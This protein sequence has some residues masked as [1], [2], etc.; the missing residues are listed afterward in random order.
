M[1]NGTEEV[2][3]N[4]KISEKYFANGTKKKTEC[5]DLALNAGFWGTKLSAS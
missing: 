5:G 4:T 3:F 2:V 1:W